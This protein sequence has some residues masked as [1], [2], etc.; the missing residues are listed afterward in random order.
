MRTMSKPKKKPVKETKTLQPEIK[1]EIPAGELKEFLS[2]KITEADWKRVTNIKAGNL[3]DNRYRVDVWMEEYKEGVM[4]P[5]V[6]IGYSYFVRYHEGMIIDK[7]EE[8]KPKK[9]RFF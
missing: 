1:P 2:D 3:W 6:W 7:T 4:C 8:T 9:E 5:K